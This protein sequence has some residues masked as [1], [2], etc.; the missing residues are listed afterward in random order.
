MMGRRLASTILLC[1]AVAVAGCDQGVEPPAMVAASA[2]APPP[3]TNRVDI[4]PAVRQNLGVTFAKVESRA[5]VRTL[6]IPG[7]F[8]LVPTARREYRAQEGGRIELLIEQYQTVKQGDALYR[9]DSPRWRELQREIADTVAAFEL[10]RASADSI[11]PYMEAHEKHHVEIENAVALWTK[12]VETLEELR[13]AGGAR[14]GELADAQ[15]SLASA[16]AALAETLEKEAELNSRARE[17]TAQL[18]AAKSRET[19]LLAS[20]ASLT[21]RS[22]DELMRA[23]E[24]VPLWQTLDV[25]EV[26]A[27]APG[28]VES[29]GT[30]SGA[31]V[32]QS[33]AVLSTVQPEQVRFRA[34]GLQ[35]DLGR[36]SDGL[37][38][39]V[40][41]PSG[42]SLDRT[43]F[44]A[45]TLSVMQTAN[46]ERRTIELV[47]TPASLDG[48]PLWCRAGVSAYLEIVL[49]GSGGEEL[50]IPLSCVARDG[51]QSIIFRRDPKDPDKAIRMEAD[52]GRDDGQWVEIRS[53]V[54]EGNEIVLDGVYQLMVA[55]SGS[56]IKGGHFHPDG[57]FHEGEDH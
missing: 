40:V 8:E 51:T 30:V 49:A 4:N 21:G 31:F 25:I 50:A 7:R 32:D 56:I 13:T 1:L 10:A 9:L 6:R 16:R 52:L 43:G 39:R 29:L 26:R 2:A 14:G 35:S 37:V 18:A 15:A 28:I 36:L 27:I 44:V 54:A 19:I 22:A 33:E 20:A 12:R 46:P 47:M 3:P 11:G 53:G 42:G 34:H 24:G 38:A 55:T 17:S 23:Q 41:P 48:L 5:V 57:T 45:G